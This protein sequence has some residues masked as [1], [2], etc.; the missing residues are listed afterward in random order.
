MSVLD[1]YDR[2]AHLTWYERQYPDLPE[3]PPETRDAAG[4]VR[5][6]AQYAGLAGLLD[7]PLGLGL[8]L[9]LGLEVSF[10]K[11]PGGIV[12]TIADHAAGLSTGIGDTVTGALEAA[13]A[14][15]GQA[16]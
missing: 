8:G 16:R 10:T 4:A 3:W 15:M 13:V 1:A 14:G 12:A 6:I 7:V 11:D 2:Q 5:A 9:G